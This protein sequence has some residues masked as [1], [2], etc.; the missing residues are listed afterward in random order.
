MNSYYGIKVIYPRACDSLQITFKGKEYFLNEEKTIKLIV[1][2][3]SSSGGNNPERIILQN[4]STC[5][6]I[7]LNYGS[8]RELCNKYKQLSHSYINITHPAYINGFYD[9]VNIELFLQKHIIYNSC[10]LCLD[11]ESM[12]SL[13]YMEEQMYNDL[14]SN[15]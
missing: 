3:K 15:K 2:D 12:N 11:I 10:F 4:I 1:E 5:L 9:Y 13:I 6:Y 7:R 14:T 8:F